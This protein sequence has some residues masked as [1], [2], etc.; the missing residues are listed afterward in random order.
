MK[1]TSQIPV[2]KN[3]RRP[4]FQVQLIDSNSG[5]AIS[6]ADSNYTVRM[7]FRAAG[8]DE[9]LA[10]IPMSKVGDGSSGTVYHSWVDSTAANVLEQ[11]Y[12]TMGGRYEGQIVIDFD[13]SPQT[14][15]TKVRF[16]VK[17]R[18]AEVA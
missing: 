18:F 15:D 14:V 4:V 10:D 9:T 2:F 7:L 12:I 17:E 11:T 8:S 13:G 3:D 1:A 5:T 16:T 6:L